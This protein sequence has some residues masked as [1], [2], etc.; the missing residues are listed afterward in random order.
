MI[1]AVL[2]DKLDANGYV[3]AS[4]VAPTHA[5]AHEELR[6]KVVVNKMVFSTYEGH[7]SLDDSTFYDAIDGIDDDWS[8]EVFEV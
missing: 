7:V 3:V 2:I 8:V 6:Q 4:V 5:S 1:I